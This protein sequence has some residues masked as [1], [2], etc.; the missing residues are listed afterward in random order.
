[1]FF[2]V[3]RRKLWK[4]SLKILKMLLFNIDLLLIWYLYVLNINI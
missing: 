4:I 3:L 1:M 2:V